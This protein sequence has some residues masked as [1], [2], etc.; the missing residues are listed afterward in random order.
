MEKWIVFAK[1]ADF[2]QKTKKYNI[3]PMLARIIR[4][5]D[6]IEERIKVVTI[7][8]KKCYSKKYDSVLN[9]YIIIIYAMHSLK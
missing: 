6:I 3:S 5:K 8:Y 2:K 7:L 4:N 9:L 1:K